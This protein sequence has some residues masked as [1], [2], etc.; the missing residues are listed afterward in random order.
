MLEKHK[1]DVNYIDSLVLF[2]EG[3]ILCEQYGCFKNIIIFGWLGA[4]LAIFER[5]ATPF[6]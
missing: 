4:A 5:C 2:E 6:S 1:I 3:K